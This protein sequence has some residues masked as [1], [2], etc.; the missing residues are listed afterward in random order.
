MKRIVVSVMTGGCRRRDSPTS[1]VRRTIAN[2]PVTQR[3]RQ[4]PRSTKPLTVRLGKCMQETV[5]D[6]RMLIPQSWPL[7]TTLRALIISLS[8]KYHD[9]E[10]L[11]VRAKARAPAQFVALTWLASVSKHIGGRPTSDLRLGR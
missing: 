5:R 4:G 10:R 9:Q 11:G 1:P 8:F 2:P 6:Q 7:N 3:R